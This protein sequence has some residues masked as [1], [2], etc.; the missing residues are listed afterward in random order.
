MDNKSLVLSDKTK[1]FP[2]KNYKSFNLE[3]YRF[4]KNRRYNKNNK[5]NKKFLS[6]QRYNKNKEYKK[7]NLSIVLPIKT[8]KIDNDFINVIDGKIAF[9]YE[10]LL[11]FKW[12][13]KYYFKEITWNFGYAEKLNDKEL[14]FK[15]FI[16]HS[17]LIKYNYQIW[18]DQELQNIKDNKYNQ[19]FYLNG[20]YYKTFYKLTYKV[21]EE[22]A[23]SYL[24]H[25]FGNVSIGNVKSLI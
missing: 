14:L 25:N 17:K 4:N 20:E 13:D 8:P 7:S 12:K 16:K 24:L 15:Y 11:V 22:T 23:I 6:D 3:D 19:V 21:S 10:K 5:N 18:I 2:N 1:D 9:I